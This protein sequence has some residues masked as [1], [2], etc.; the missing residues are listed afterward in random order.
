METNW[1]CGLQVKTQ[2]RS[3]GSGLVRAPRMGMGFVKFQLK[4]GS[5]K[6]RVR[7]DS[8][9]REME[10]KRGRVIMFE[11]QRREAYKEAIGNK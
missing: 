11:I 10:E 1:D 9:R 8:V 7:M 3:L 5:G 4:L 2:L 6:K